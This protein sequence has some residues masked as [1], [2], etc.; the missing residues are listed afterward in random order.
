MKVIGTLFWYES[1][2]NIKRLIL[3]KA[4]YLTITCFCIE[5]NKAVSVQFGLRHNFHRKQ[6]TFS[7]LEG[8]ELFIKHVRLKKKTVDEMDIPY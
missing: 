4:K 2:K 8:Q 3:K 6:F 1:T 5:R 7:F